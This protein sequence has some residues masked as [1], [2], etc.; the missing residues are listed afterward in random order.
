M[1]IPSSS[2]V[3]HMYDG[4]IAYGLIDGKVY[5]CFI[6]VAPWNVPNFRPPAPFT[7]PK[8]GKVYTLRNGHVGYYPEFGI[9][10]EYY[11]MIYSRGKESFYS[12]LD[13]CTD[14]LK[15]LFPNHV[16]VIE[17]V[18]KHVKSINNN[19]NNIKCD[20]DVLLPGHDSWIPLKELDLRS[21]FQFKVTQ[22]QKPS[23]HTEL[24]VL[25]P[26]ACVGDL[27]YY[28]KRKFDVDL[29]S[30]DFKLREGNLDVSDTA[31][32]L[33]ELSVP[34]LA[35]LTLQHKDLQGKPNPNPSY[36]KLKKRGPPPAIKK[37]NH[38]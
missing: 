13:F 7:G 33:S 14:H 34:R 8:E 9:I 20:V 16:S 26:N 36:G 21:L 3:R 28:V 37:K 12:L 35:A 6:G 22:Y 19:N 5:E 17:F 4:G 30:F 29:D 27:V 31:I 10:Q 11:P 23:S 2:I 1:S 32:S 25:F 38:L 24:I 18:Y 15:R